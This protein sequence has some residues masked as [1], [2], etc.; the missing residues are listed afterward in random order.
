MCIRALLEKKQSLVRVRKKPMYTAIVPAFDVLPKPIPR[1]HSLSLFSDILVLVGMSPHATPRAQAT[2]VD[3]V[4]FLTAPAHCPQ[5]GC[6]RVFGIFKC[7]SCTHF[8]CCVGK[9]LCMSFFFITSVLRN[10][11]AHRTPVLCFLDREPRTFEEVLLQRPEIHGQSTCVG[12]PHCPNIVPAQ[13]QPIVSCSWAERKS[14]FTEVFVNG[15]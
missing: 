2:P 9:C 5:Q 3:I 11:R 4:F 14:L 12:H 13:R 15:R 7:A 8:L 1:K 6:L 10:L